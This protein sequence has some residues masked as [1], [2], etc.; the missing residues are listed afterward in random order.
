[1]KTA[2]A[3]DD[4]GSLQEI[5]YRRFKR[6]QEGDMGFAALPD[7]IF[8][9]G[10]KAQVAAV[11]KILNAM[12][13]DIPVLGMVKDDKHRSRGLVYDGEEI[14]LKKIPVLYKYVGSVQEETH[15]FAIE[16]H[17][18]L[19]DKKMRAS[20][21]DNIS[22]VGEKRRNALLKHFGS[23]EKIKLAE[24]DELSEV[25]G[26]TERTAKSIKNYFNKPQEDFN[27]A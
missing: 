11:L 24:I 25:D 20:V 4:Y 21:L 13:I 18:G 3:S 14:E 6:A 22:G 26:I 17:R 2:S 27:K 19:R 12:Q 1:V 7:L 16:Y 15:R 10:G 23:I 9:D 5:I 8:V